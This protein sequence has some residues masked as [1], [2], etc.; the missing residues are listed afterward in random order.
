MVLRGAYT[1]TG[2]GAITL[3]WTIWQGG[4][5]MNMNAHEG[6]MATSATGMQ[7]Y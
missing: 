6:M 3:A 4:V 1:S 2:A 5:Q 7:I